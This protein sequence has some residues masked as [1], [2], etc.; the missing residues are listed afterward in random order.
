M[1]K[2]C[3]KDFL[4]QL[5]DG[6]STYNTIGAMRTTSMSLNK[7]NVDVTTKDDAPWRAL[8]DGCGIKSMSV[9]GGGVF[10]DDEFVEDLIQAFMSSTT[11]KT[12]KLVSGAGDEFDG[13]F[14]ITTISRAG[15]YN[16]EETFDFTLE[17]SGTIT[18]TAAT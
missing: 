1:A 14:E 10:S 9:S 5:Y 18:Y 6:S 7:E 8:L 15:E 16:A 17:S 3:G 13:D 11:I 4:I 2:F 12:F